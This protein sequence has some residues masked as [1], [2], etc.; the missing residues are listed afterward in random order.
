M[1]HHL[2]D[3]LVAGQR[4]LGLI[5][6]GK[7]GELTEALEVHGIDVAAQVARGALRIQSASPAYLPNGS[8]DPVGTIRMVAQAERDAL[9]AGYR[10]LCAAA[11]MSW[12]LADAPGTERLA[13]YEYLIERTVYQR[14]NIVGLCQYDATRFDGEEL[15]RIRSAHPI[16]VAARRRSPVAPAAE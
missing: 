5:E 15:R 7:A 16:Q 8:F 10:G 2:S 1:S 11:D 9:L 12:A 14:L 3:G 6:H 13:E 4:A